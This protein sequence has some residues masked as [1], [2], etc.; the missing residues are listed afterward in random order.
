VITRPEGVEHGDAYAVDSSAIAVIGR[1]VS[2]LFAF[3]VFVGSFLSGAWTCDP[4]DVAQRSWTEHYAAPEWTEMVWLG[5]AILLLALATALAASR[6]YRRAAAL[7][8]AVQMLLS[9]RLGWLLHASGHDTV[10]TWTVMA[11]ATGL[12]MLLL[13]PGPRPR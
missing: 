6:G 7:F 2:P 8:L 10:L 9:L 1:S 13:A 3:G 5:L 12:G 4:C 11:C